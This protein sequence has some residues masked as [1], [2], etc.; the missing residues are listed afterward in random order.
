MT[1]TLYGQNFAERSEQLL[2][3]VETVLADI[4]RQQGAH[5][6]GDGGDSAFRRLL[7]YA[8]NHPQ[9]S[10]ALSPGAHPVD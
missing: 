5:R 4:S 8:G 2:A 6:A 7:L 3:H 9:L 10:G 1:L